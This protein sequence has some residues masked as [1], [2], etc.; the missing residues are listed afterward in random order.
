MRV[1]GEREIHR[2][3]WRL[4][5]GNHFVRARRLGMRRPELVAYLVAVSEGYSAA[6]RTVAWQGLELA[7]EAL[8][9]GR[10]EPRATIEQVLACHDRNLE[11]AITVGG[12]HPRF[13]ERYLACSGRLHQR[14][15]L[16]RFSDMAAR[17]VPV[18]ERGAVF[19]LLKTI[20]DVLDQR[21][22]DDATTPEPRGDLPPPAP[23]GP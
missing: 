22:T 15:L 8:G 17:A 23:F 18:G 11:L 13:A 6:A 14:P 16:R 20:V 3:A 1:L 19:L 2:A 10:G 4:T 12:A 9:A 7:C 21:P 5:A